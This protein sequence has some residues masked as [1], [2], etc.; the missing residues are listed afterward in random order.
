MRNDSLFSNVIGEMWKNTDILLF[1]ISL[2]LLFFILQDAVTT[3]NTLQ[4][5][6]STNSFFTEDKINKYVV[7]K[8][9]D[10]RKYLLR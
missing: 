8:V 3:L 5:R 7:N 4:S 1:I 2:I 9:E 10:T 6:N